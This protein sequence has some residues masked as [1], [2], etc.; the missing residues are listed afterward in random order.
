MFL[1]PGLWFYLIPLSTYLWHTPR[2]SS[3]TNSFN[4]Y[5]TPLS[6]FISTWSLNHYLY[7]ELYL[8]NTK[9]TF[10]TAVTHLQHTNSDISW[11]TSNLLSLNLSK[12]EFMLI[13]LPQQIYKITNSSA[14][15]P[16]NTPI[17]PTDSAHNLGFVFDTNI[18]PSVNKSLP[19]RVLEITISVTFALSDTP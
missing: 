8:L 5:T 2:M 17:T 11:M 9:K 12:T 6:S 14:F 10:I 1:Y 19:C 4:M 16:S 15:L 13:G 3:R 18:L 7:A